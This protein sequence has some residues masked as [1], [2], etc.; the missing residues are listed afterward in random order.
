MRRELSGV[1]Q[2]MAVCV[3]F[4]RDLFSAQRITIRGKVRRAGKPRDPRVLAHALRPVAIASS[5]RHPSRYRAPHV[6][7][8]GG[9]SFRG[10]SK[11]TQRSFSRTSASI[12]EIGLYISILSIFSASRCSDRCET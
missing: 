7:R 11:K 9:N 10:G 3:R 12:V 8:I 6:V 2:S 4:A 5:N 1:W